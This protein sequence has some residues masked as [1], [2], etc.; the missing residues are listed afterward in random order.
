MRCSTNYAYCGAYLS[1]KLG[2]GRENQTR[3]PLCLE[4]DIGFEPMTF[5]S[6]TR[7]ST[8]ELILPNTGCG[9]RNR[10]GPKGYEP[11]VRHYTSPRLFWWRMRESNSHEDLAKVPG[12]HYINPP[13]IYYVV[14]RQGIEPRPMDLEA[15]VLP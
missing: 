2:A 8:T 15:I 5:S 13:K 14:T 11:S 3:Q 9:R 7:H 10:T 12:S 6:A 1:T 4:Q